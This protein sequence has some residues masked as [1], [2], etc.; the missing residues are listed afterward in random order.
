MITSKVTARTI[1][2]PRGI[3]ITSLALLSWGLVAALVFV[4]GF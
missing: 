1:T 2:I 4:L 3:T